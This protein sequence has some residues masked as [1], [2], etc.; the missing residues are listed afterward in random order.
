LQGPNPKSAYSKEQL[1][2]EYQ[3]I[4]DTIAPHKI[5]NVKERFENTIISIDTKITAGKIKIE[6]VDSDYKLKQ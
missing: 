4:I 1:Y 5:D 2:I 3:K 6:K